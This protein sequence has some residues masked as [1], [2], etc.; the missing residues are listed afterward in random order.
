M[1]CESLEA[2]IRRT[3]LVAKGA[4]WSAW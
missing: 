4:R 1:A 2:V 3:G